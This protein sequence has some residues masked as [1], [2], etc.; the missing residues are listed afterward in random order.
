LLAL[1]AEDEPED[2]RLISD[3]IMLSAQERSPL[4]NV[5]TTARLLKAGHCL[6]S[7]VTVGEWLDAWLKTKKKLRATGTL[8]Y[9]VDIRCHLRPRIG[10]IRLDKLRVEH[11]DEM[12]EG[13]AATNQEIV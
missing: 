8:R 7:R 1:A 12:F 5:E 9:E 11:L 10:L 3:M 6:T 2:R 13:I 4:P